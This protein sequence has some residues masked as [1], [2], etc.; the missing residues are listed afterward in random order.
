MSHILQSK[1]RAIEVMKIRYNRI[2][3]LYNNRHRM[4]GITEAEFE[5]AFFIVSSRTVNWEEVNK[6]F[7]NF[8]HQLF[9]I[10]EF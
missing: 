6:A 4:T 9:Q 10:L 7:P 8:L 1:N 3:N 2:D 5:K